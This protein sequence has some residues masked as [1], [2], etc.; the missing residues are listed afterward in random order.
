MVYSIL[1]II[2][3]LPNIGIFIVPEYFL[4]ACYNC[5]KFEEAEHENDFWYHA[6]TVYDDDQEINEPQGLQKNT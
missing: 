1:S 5:P 6:A 2:K 4:E 3:E